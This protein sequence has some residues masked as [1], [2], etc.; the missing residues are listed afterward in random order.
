VAS[1]FEKAR[2]RP[3]RGEITG[4]NAIVAFTGAESQAMNKLPNSVMPARL[5]VAGHDG[6]S[7]QRPDSPHTGYFRPAPTL[8]SLPAARI[9]KTS[10]NCGGRSPASSSQHRRSLWSL[11]H[12]NLHE[13]LWQHDLESFILYFSCNKSVTCLHQYCHQKN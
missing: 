11:Y 5:T 9:S 4:A 7:G 1:N 13:T 12:G 10:V 8:S 3:K 6:R 2:R